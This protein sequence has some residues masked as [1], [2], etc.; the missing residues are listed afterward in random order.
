M[1]ASLV[2]PQRLLNASIVELGDDFLLAPALRRLHHKK[3]LTIVGIGSSITARHG[4]CTHSLPGAASCE[5]HSPRSGGWLRLFFNGLNATF[6]HSRHRLLNAGMPASAP[7]AFTECLTWLPSEVDMYVLEFVAARDIAELAARLLTR[8]PTTSVRSPIILFVAFHRW[9]MPMEGAHNRIMR[10]ARLAGMPFVSQ[11]H[12]L[13]SFRSVAWSTLEGHARRCVGAH[14]RAGS[15]WRV[16]STVISDE[17]VDCWG[18]AVQ[19]PDGLHPTT[20]VGQAFM[21]QA[22]LTW[23]HQANRRF[24]MRAQSGSLPEAL[25]GALTDKPTDPLPA[26][27]SSS[28]PG[29]LGKRL[30]LEASVRRLTGGSRSLASRRVTLACFT[31]DAR[32]MHDASTLGEA[33]REGAQTTLMDVSDPRASQERSPD[34]NATLRAM[35]APRALLLPWLDADTA[36]REATRHL[37]RHQKKR[38]STSDAIGPDGGKPAQLLSRRGFAFLLDFAKTTGGLPAGDSSGAPA[39]ITTLANS[40]HGAIGGGGGRQGT[41]ERHTGKRRSLPSLREAKASLGGFCPGDSVTVDVSLP[42]STGMEHG[43]RPKLVDRG[44]R[45]SAASLIRPYVALDHLTSWRGMGRARIECVAGCTC[46]PT[47][48][49]GHLPDERASLRSMHTFEVSTLAKCALRLTV[50]NE[51]RSG[52]HRVYLMR[53]AVGGHMPMPESAVDALLTTLP[54]PPS[55]PPPPPPPSPPSCESSGLRGDAPGFKRCEPFCQA[56]NAP[57]HCLLCKCS[58]CTWCV[59]GRPADGSKHAARDLIAAAAAGRA[60]IQAARKAAL[61]TLPPPPPMPPPSGTG[62]HNESTGVYICNVSA[63]YAHGDAAHNEQTLRRGQCAYCAARMRSRSS[64]IRLD[65]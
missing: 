54:S 33:L 37:H 31:F 63:A 49:D 10:T 43:K 4:G 16:P 52:E 8:K 11:L 25:S 51:S 57:R 36:A 45:A 18:P 56:K 47:V 42:S 34:S 6:P 7:T 39:G 17:D 41:E 35:S 20:R 61:R 19:A 53:I 50:L 26:V 22:M 2:A 58:A 64:E 27:D 5:P 65:G 12:G 14:S 30:G 21:G 48:L 60:A 13:A 23:F 55:P 29:S 38:G 62:Q 46:A 44:T 40:S 32:R 15:S 59:D 1:D 24:E 28:E 3:H 9:V